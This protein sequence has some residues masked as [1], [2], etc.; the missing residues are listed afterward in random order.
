MV[1]IKDVATEAGVAVGTVSKYIN[2]KPVRE[3]TRQRIAR[4]VEK[5]DYRVNTYA[6]GLKTQKT[7]TVALILPDIRNPFF[8][9]F[10]YFAEKALELR[11]NKMLLC[12]STGDS[13]MELKYINMAKQCKVDGIIGITYSDID[14]AITADIPFIS[15]DRHFSAQVP[16]VTADNFGGGMLA[17]AKLF[18]LGCA[19]L[20]YI[21]TGSVVFGEADRR[22]AGFMEGCRQKSLS[23]GVFHFYEKENKTPE[24]IYFDLFEGHIKNGVLDFDG[25]FVVTDEYAFMAI[26]AMRKLGVRVPEDVQVIGFDGIRQ[27]NRFEFLVSTICQPVKQM[28]EVAVSYLFLKDKKTIPALTALPVDD[29]KGGTTRD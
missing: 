13:Q 7:E 16:C 17:A 2:N 22:R 3:E 25:L 23:P 18:E 9:S 11:N 28:A 6:R 1:T 15:I 24:E 27:F 10:A 5:F 20:A 29:C 14:D 12:S 8:S 21:G 19:R 4:A 26:K